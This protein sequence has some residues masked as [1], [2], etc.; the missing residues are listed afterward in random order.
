MALFDVFLRFFSP[1]RPGGPGRKVI[2][3]QPR[4]C[5]APDGSPERPRHRPG[6]KP[7]SLE[8]GALG[9]FGERPLGPSMG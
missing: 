3:R 1:G 2:T 6:R 4:R 5:C 7:E 8:G 9:S